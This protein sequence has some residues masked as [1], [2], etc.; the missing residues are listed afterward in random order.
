MEI[1]SLGKTDFETITKACIQAFADYEIQLDAE[2]LG[3][4]WK[5][6]GFNPDLSFA[7]FEGENKVNLQDIAYL[8]LY[9]A[10]LRK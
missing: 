6:R 3:I 9:P 8:N 5:R 10:T 7:A 2:E 4:M 1:K